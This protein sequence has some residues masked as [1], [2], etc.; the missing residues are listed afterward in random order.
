MG[1]N[2]GAKWAFS[3]ALCPSSPNEEKFDQ[4]W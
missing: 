2:M 3:A 1:A 4:F